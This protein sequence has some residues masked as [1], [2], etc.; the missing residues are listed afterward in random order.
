M[1]LTDDYFS[2][3]KQWKEE[4]GEKTIVLMQVGSFFEVYAL[5]DK[6]GKLIGSHI[7]EFARINDMV[8]ATKSTCVGSKPVKMAG[9]GLAQIDK[10]IRRLQEHGYTIAIYTQDIQGKNTTRSLSQIISPGTFFSQDNTE[11]SNN[12]SCIWIHFSP[13]NKIIN[14]Q[15]SIGISN[16]D[17][18]TG[19]TCIIQFEKEFFHNPATYDDIERQLAIFRPSECI[20]VSNLSENKVNDIIDFSSIDCNKIHKIIMG[21]SNNVSSSMNKFAKNAEKQTYQ[22]EIIRKFYPTIPEETI[23]EYFPT[24]FLALQ[25]FTFLLDFVY[26]HNPTLVN[27]LSQPKFENYTENLIL[28]NH[29]LRQLNM[30]DDTRHKGRLRS[31]GALLN[32]CVTNMGKRRFNYNLNNPITNI[33]KLNESYELT[34]YL[35]ETLQWGAYRNDMTGLKDIEKFM[36]KLVFKKE[37]ISPKDFAILAHD[38]KVVIKMDESTSVDRELNNYINKHLKVD[39]SEHCNKI[40]ANLNHNFS[41]KKCE[42]I[43]DMSSGQLIDTNNSDLCFI[44]KG[45]SLVIDEL[46]KDAIDGN[47]KLEAIRKYLND[48]LCKVEKSTSTKASSQFI[49]IHE[50]PKTDPVLMGTKRRVTLLQNEL[51]KQNESKKQNKTATITYESKY[52]NTKETFE[53]QL[54]DLEIGYCGSN[55]KDMI[56]FNNEI[57]KLTNNIQKSREKLI[58]EISLFFSKFIDD[59]LQFQSFIEDIITYITLM[60]IAQ[61]KAYIANKYNYCKPKIDKQAEKSYMDFTEIRHPLI[62]HLQTRELYVTND[63]NIGEYHDGLLLYG[64]NAVGKTSFIKS[65]GIS[66][67]MAQAGLYVPCKTFTYYPYKCIFTRILGNDNIFKGLSTFATEMSELRTILKMADKHSLVLGDELCSGTEVDSA[68]SIFTTGLEMLHKKESTFLFATHFHEINNYDE[69]KCLDRLTTM[70]MEV[71]YDKEQD[72]LIYDRKLKPGPG[73]CMY[74]LEVCKS[75]N[76]PDEFL[77]RAHDIRMKYNKED[78]NILAEDGSH[79]NKKKLKGNC[80]ICKKKRASEVHHLAHQKTASKTNSYIGSFHKNHLANL[81]NICEDCHNKIHETGEQH[82]VVKTTKGYMLKKQ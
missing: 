45:V 41:L 78:L 51:K 44:N 77:Q 52:S 65:I 72:M 60:D 33:E 4:Y 40:I 46:F 50:T 7:E 54:D 69:I 12:I 59:F 55:K 1:T 57:R 11:L 47:E 29:S 74:G 8:I 71:I 61:C 49:K 28:A 56:I 82:K 30:L 58:G 36:R 64:T 75:L 76:L 23:L 19:Q 68:L 3:T 32:N 63:L 18:Y 38:L 35:L 25:S 5:E 66:V 24:H 81:V 22:R 6:D 48:I 73:H 27:R 79:F 42:K 26:Q 43:H 80:E 2:Y 31:V 67:I 34:E 15:L 37:R 70:H 20:I 62:E 53:I 9:F 17:I 39:I 10:Y 13:A 16:I 21:E 14:S